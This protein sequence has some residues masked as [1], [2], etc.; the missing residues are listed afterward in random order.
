[1]AKNGPRK[2]N[3]ITGLG[4]DDQMSGGTESDKIL[5][6]DGNDKTIER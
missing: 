6:A 4:D 3:K 1:M 5:G 2:F